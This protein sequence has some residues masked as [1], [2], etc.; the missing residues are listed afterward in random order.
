MG[1][2]RNSLGAFLLVRSEI[3]TARRPGPILSRD[4]SIPGEERPL[5]DSCKVL[6]QVPAASCDFVLGS[7][8]LGIMRWGK[9]VVQND[10]GKTPPLVDA[11]ANAERTLQRRIDKGCVVVACCAEDRYV[12]CL[13]IHISIP[14]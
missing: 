4:N 7:W 11:E 2:T 1:E 10:L 8:V 14:C 9:D 12:L 13:R 6:A 5:C 3:V